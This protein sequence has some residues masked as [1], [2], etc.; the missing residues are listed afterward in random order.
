MSSRLRNI[1][2]YSDSAW[3]SPMCPVGY[4]SWTVLTTNL[5][6]SLIRDDDILHLI[7]HGCSEKNISILLNMNI[8]SYCWRVGE[9]KEPKAISTI[10]DQSPLFWYCWGTKS[11]RS[12]R[13]GALLRK[14]Y[15]PFK[16]SALHGTHIVSTVAHLWISSCFVVDIGILSGYVRS[17]QFRD[18]S[19]DVWLCHPQHH[20]P[21]TLY[22]GS[23]EQ[24]ERQWEI[25]MLCMTCWPNVR[26]RT[27]D[28]EERERRAQL[29]T[30]Q[31]RWILSESM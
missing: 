17:F 3:K 24:I 30:K 21:R 4:D 14:L 27:E 9:V 25:W 15:V 7:E 2:G 31:F 11:K 10:A 12:I 13:S 29:V 22:L 8:D 20:F 28:S 18:L 19:L 6:Y 1:F 26:L 16:C 23:W 5:A